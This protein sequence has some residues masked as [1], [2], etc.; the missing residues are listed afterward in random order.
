MDQDI[1]LKISHDV[2]Q[3]LQRKLEGMYSE[4]GKYMQCAESFIGLGDVERAFVHVDYNDD[5]DIH[6]EHKPLYEGKKQG[7]T[8]K[9]VLLSRKKEGEEE[10]RRQEMSG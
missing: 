1:P 2:S 5:H 7:R 6:E 9:D 8:L 4:P 3:S 10:L